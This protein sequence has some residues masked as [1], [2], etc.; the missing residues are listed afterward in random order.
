MKFLPVTV[1]GKKCSKC[2]YALL[3]EGSTVTLINESV[4]KEIGANTK[5]VCVKLKGIGE[6]NAIVFLNQKLTRGREL[7]W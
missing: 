7:S 3:D 6:S 4:L 2:V 5:N 1:Y